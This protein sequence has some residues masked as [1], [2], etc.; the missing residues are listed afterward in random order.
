MQ[1]YRRSQKPLEVLLW[2]R[3]RAHR[4]QLF[5]HKIVTFF[6]KLHRIP[7]MAPSFLNYA[8]K[9]SRW[10]MKQL[11]KIAIWIDQGTNESTY[12]F[13]FTQ[14]VT[15]SSNGTLPFEIDEY[16]ITDSSLWNRYCLYSLFSSSSYV[17]ANS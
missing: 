5:E 13:F 4:G 12:K 3:G 9:C 17:W 16:F 10:K 6:W 7:Q 15:Q 8:K 1:P 11:L 2:M 14:N